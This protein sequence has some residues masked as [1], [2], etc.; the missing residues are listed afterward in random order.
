VAAVLLGADMA[1]ALKARIGQALVADIGTPASHGGSASMSAIRGVTYRICA[2]PPVAGMAY[3]PQG[4][5]DAEDDRNDIL[6]AGIVWGET[7]STGSAHSGAPTAMLC[8]DTAAL[9]PFDASD[10]PDDPQAGAGVSAATAAAAT[11]GLF[12]RTDAAPS[13]GEHV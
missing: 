3:T 8:L 5:G 7:P 10:E 9:P 2:P 1:G 13:P 11:G 12:Q 6:R 4:A